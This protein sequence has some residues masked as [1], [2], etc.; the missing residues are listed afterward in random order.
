[1]IRGYLVCLQGR[2]GE[3]HQR[4]SATSSGV[5]M[6]YATI[7]IDHDLLAFWVRWRSRN[8]HCIEVF[9]QRHTMKKPQAQ[10]CDT[11]SELK[12]SQCT[13][14]RPKGIMLQKIF[15]FLFRIS[16]KSLH[17]SCYYS[18]HAPHCCRYFIF[19]TNDNKIYKVLIFYLSSTT[20]MALFIHGT[21]FS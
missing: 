1:M 10:N 21:I 18:F 8:V 15:V 20:I 19:C 7:T 12:Q 11:C 17:Y 6:M 14:D 9:K 16:P 4:S 3:L 13:A 5:H 2:L